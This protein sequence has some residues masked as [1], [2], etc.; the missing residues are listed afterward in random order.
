MHDA[1]HTALD[2]QHT[3]HDSGVSR[4]RLFGAGAVLGSTAAIAS[5]VA[6]AG[7]A[8][9]VVLGQEVD[10]GSLGITGLTVG[11]HTNLF[12]SFALTS[13]TGIGVISV[14]TAR[15]LVTFNAG[16]GHKALQIFNA[17][18]GNVHYV[19]STPGETSGNWVHDGKGNLYFSSGNKLMHVS[20][21]GRSI[22]QFGTA[23]TGIMEMYE[24]Q[25]DHE[26][27]LWAGTYPAGVLVRIHPDTGREVARTPPLGTGN[28]YARGLSISP[29][30]KTVWSGTGTADPD[31][32]RVDVDTPSAPVRVSIPGRGRDSFVPQTVALGRKVFVWHDN[33]AGDE[34]VSVYDVVSKT[35]SAS[36]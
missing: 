3:P 28:K 4:R 21:P 6:G 5:T 23:G 2:A 33:T 14:G 27:Y 18:T 35:W 29:D 8:S 32:F 13:A 24:F 30:Q 15:Y 7:P 1:Q 25:I 36:P 26:G 20:V 11:R 10:T 31:L 19:A 34:I 17:D 16:D 12:R 9:A 22:R